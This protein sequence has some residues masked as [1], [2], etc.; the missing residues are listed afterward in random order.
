MFLYEEQENLLYHLD[1][2]YDHALWSEHIEIHRS[3]RDCE[4][5]NDTHDCCNDEDINELD[6]TVAI[7][8]EHVF[9]FFV[10]RNELN[11]SDQLQIG[12][13]ILL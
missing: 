11:R 3:K 12:P 6:A 7:D 13:Q 1:T 8:V 5:S 9:F 4:T 10:Q 2:V